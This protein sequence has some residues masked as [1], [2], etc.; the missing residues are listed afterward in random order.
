MPKFYITDS[1]VRLVVLED[2]FDSAADRFVKHYEGRGIMLK[3][4]IF[5]S[6]R[7]FNCKP[8]EVYD[9]DALLAQ[10]SG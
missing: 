3:P 10:Q 6:E 2:D 4:N 8:F 7:G 1:Y 9:T 5:I